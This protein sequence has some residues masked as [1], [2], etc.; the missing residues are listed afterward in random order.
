MLGVAALAE[1][2][3]YYVP[4]VDNLH[5]GYARCLR[6]GHGGLSGCND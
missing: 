5:A 3:A 6:R 1:I 4:G 2:L